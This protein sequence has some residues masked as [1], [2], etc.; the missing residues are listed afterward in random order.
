ML[1]NLGQACRYMGAQVRRIADAG[2]GHV[3]VVGPYNLGRSVWVRGSAN[4]SLLEAA[5]SQFNQQMLVS[6]VDLGQ[7]V[8]Y[9]DAALYFNLVT[10]SPPSYDLAEAQK[11]GCTSVDPGPGIG[12]GPN[13]VNS[14]LCTNNTLSAPNAQNA[15]VFADAIYPTPHAHR[16]FGEYA[17]NRVRERW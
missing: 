12:I 9:V 11:I 5:S 16:L 15:Y 17:W 2:A 6:V 8:L 7:K 14:F 10:A 1:A 13:Q 4:E 3:V